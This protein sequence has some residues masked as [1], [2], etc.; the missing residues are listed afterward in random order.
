M[1]N[2]LPQ[3]LHRRWLITGWAAIFL[4]VQLFAVVHHHP[5]SATQDKTCQLCL[6]QGEGSAGLAPVSPGIPPARFLLL[7]EPAVH[8]VTYVS[9]QLPTAV[10]R[11]PPPIIS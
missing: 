2:R 4:A 11:A 5:V 7:P 3:L 8:V 6:L 10:A 9:R 1:N